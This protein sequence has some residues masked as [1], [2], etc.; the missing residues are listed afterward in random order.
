M[1]TFAE[2]VLLS[3]GFVGISANILTLLVILISKRTTPTH[4]YIMYAASMTILEQF[5]NP[6][7]HHLYTLDFYEQYD[8]KLIMTSIF[9]MIVFGRMV[10]TILF[11]LMDYFRWISTYKWIVIVAHLST[12]V[13]INVIYFI[14]E[15]IYFV[16]YIMD[17]NIM[18]LFLGFML[19]YLAHRELECLKKR[20]QTDDE[21]RLRYILIL[22]CIC[23]K[24]LEFVI[25]AIEY[26]LAIMSR[27]AYLL[28]LA[29][30]FYQLDSVFSLIVLCKVDRVF[31]TNCIELFKM[32]C[33]FQRGKPQFRILL[34]DNGRLLQQNA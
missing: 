32:C 28:C 5:T 1:D 12:I 7:F 30:G 4:I 31:K 20:K 19:L 18:I 27:G 22:T 29:V 25:L 17:Y 6:S 34:N 23:T 3:T 14:I 21:S 8:G 2:V 9:L 13:F 33:W 15:E 26:N 11:F 10:W 24:I 16:R